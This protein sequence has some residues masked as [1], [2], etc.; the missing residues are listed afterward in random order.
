[1]DK[2]TK[3]FLTLFFLFVIIEKT[4]GYHMVNCERIKREGK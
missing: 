3:P 2:S 1:M 4:Y